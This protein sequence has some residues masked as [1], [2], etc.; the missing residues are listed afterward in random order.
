MHYM[1]LMASINKLILLYLLIVMGVKN[2]SLINIR[3]VKA[4]FNLKRT[5]LNIYK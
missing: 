4:A 3:N 2:V 1:V 5:G